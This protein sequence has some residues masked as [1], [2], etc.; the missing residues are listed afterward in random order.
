MCKCVDLRGWRAGTGKLRRSHGGIPSRTPVVVR[1]LPVFEGVITA[2]QLGFPDAF[3][4]QETSER[5]PIFESTLL[6][7]G[8]YPIS[9]EIKIKLNEGLRPSGL[10]FE[11]IDRSALMIVQE[12]MGESVDLLPRGSYTGNIE[13]FSAHQ[14]ALNSGDRK[15]G[16]RGLGP[17]RKLLAV[18]GCFMLSGVDVTAT[19]EGRRDP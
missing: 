11:K 6:N 13:L 3:C 4:V 15:V 12:H 14:R 9:V 7:W 5:D 19:E 16:I 1:V 10:T 8:D 2:Y 17:L 18:E